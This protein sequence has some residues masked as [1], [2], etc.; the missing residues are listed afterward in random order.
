MVLGS[1]GGDSSSREGLEVRSYPAALAG[2]D[3]IV[4]AV[5]GSALGATLADHAGLLDG[6]LLLDATN[7]IEGAQYHQLEL[8]REHVPNARVARAWCSLGWSNF[9]SP[10]I[11]GVAMDLLWCGPS[12]D[13]GRLIEDLITST[14]LHPIRTGGLDTANIVDTATRLVLSLIFQGGFP[15]ELGIKLVR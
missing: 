1:R 5:P 8:F 12:G 7:N 6:Q 9:L 2:A 4:L 15:H 13:D 3:A 11:D 14:G 10:V